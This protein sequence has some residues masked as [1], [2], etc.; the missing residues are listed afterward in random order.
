MT[1]VFSTL[2]RCNAGHQCGYGHVSRC[3]ALA[4]ALRRHG[5][6]RVLFVLDSADAAA[7]VGEKGFA[8]HVLDA[9]APEADFARQAAAEHPDLLVLDVRPAPAL[10][11]LLDARR[12][13]RLTAVLDSVGEERFAADVLYLPPV[14]AVDRTDWSGFHGLLRVGPQWMLTGMTF[15]PPP[16]RTP[17]HPF[18]LLISMGGSDP[19]GYTRRLAPLVCSLCAGLGPATG[20]E[21]EMRNAAG[22]A[23]KVLPGVVVGPGFKARDALM[24]ELAALPHPPV[25][26]NAPGDMGAVFGWCDA[27]VL[28]LCVSAYELARSARPGLYICPDSDYL[29]HAEVFVR[30]GFGRIL[31][32]AAMERRDLLEPLLAAFVNEAADERAAAVLRGKTRRVFPRDAADAVAGDLLHLLHTTP[33]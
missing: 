23:R 33:K 3:L 15:A 1:P 10:P 32:L 30:L 27:A 31:P 17:G 18:H 9:A 25:I 4:A 6:G 2:I 26:F 13:S 28:P 12:H 21:P 7:L 29:E 22:N 5:A 20:P 14:P 24:A 16:G 8:V 11:V 19:W